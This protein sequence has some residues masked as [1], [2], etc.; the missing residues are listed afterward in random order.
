MT[1]PILTLD[2]VSLVLPNGTPLF[3]ELTEQ[4]D[5]R[6]TGLVGRNG[7]GK[8]LLAQL[9]AGLL[10]PS[11]GQC[12]SSGKVRYLAQHLTPEKYPHVAALAGF[13]NTLAALLRIETGSV[14]PADFEQVG[15]DWDIRQ[16]LHTQ[17][18]SAGLGYLSPES[19]VSQLSG[20][21]A[22]RVALIGATLSDAD[23]LI[24]DEPTNH[25]DGPSR[26][27]L[28]QQL[29]RWSGGL[30]VISHDRAL[31]QQMARIVELSSLGL[32]SYGG[33]YAFYQQA[34]TQETTAA[35]QKLE[36]LKVE[37]KREEQALRE[38]REKHE[39]RQSRGERRGKEAN[40]AN[41]LLGRQKGRSEA[42]AGKLQ[43]QQ[44]EARAQLS[45]Q[46]QEAAKH[47]ET[48]AHIAMHSG[49]L[50]TTTA[51]KVA[52]LKDVTLPFAAPP[53]NQITLDISGGQ[54]I[55]VVGPNGCGKST[56]LKVLA[57]LLP[58]IS[59]LREAWV[60]MAYLDQ[61]LSCL[62]PQRTV[63]EQ[64]LEVNSVTGESQLR[65]QLAQLGLDASRALL[66]CARLSGGEQLKA[67]LAKVIYASSPAD[68][69]LL[70]EPSNHL[71]LPS[72]AALE[73]L[74]NQYQGTLL[75]VSHDEAFLAQI[76]LTHWLVAGEKGWE[77][78]HHL[79]PV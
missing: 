50:T 66:P 60:N 71:D 70:D 4:F 20:G 12:N 36:R 18:E 74:L 54:R 56:L 76:G 41:I 25:L 45:Q 78:I 67:A 33:N 44:L 9:L 24:L 51:Q 34:K 35:A 52:A 8:S 32:R 62:D 65:M 7:V 49:S 47:I 14:D 48:A 39:K 53:F 79:N 61:R 15:D 68:C 5:G 59:G 29:Q 46:V 40:Q 64:L 2:R 63:L 10:V 1:N 58:P 43:K 69:L 57:G 17:L 77:L 75:V 31:L 28:M 55:G 26:R 73:A 23:F 6:H 3:T 30:L 72:L 37:R 21:E 19:S 42:S 16:R 27:A 13:E 22:M 38:Q 11:S